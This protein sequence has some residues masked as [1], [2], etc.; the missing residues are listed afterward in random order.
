[1]KLNSRF[2]AV[3][4]ALTL[5]V[6]GA[7]LPAHAA[8]ITFEAAPFGGGFTGPITE[9][10]FTYTKASGGLFVE[11]FGHPGHDMEGT[12]IEG[13]GVLDIV[14]SSSGAFTF[15]SLDYAAYAG[16][17]VGSQTL[18]ITGYLGGLAVGADTYTLANTSSASPAFSNWTLESASSLAGVKIDDLKITL[19]GGLTDS[20]LFFQAV[21]NVVLG[22]ATVPEPATWAM[23]L[24]GFG[25]V[26]ATLRARRGM[27]SATA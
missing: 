3:A 24:V 8:T 18:H 27:A 13:G 14:Q 21:D 2:V 7:G 10:G 5:G 1:M 4:A 12:A 6:L 11:S 25:A 23:M 19:N 22:S 26:G 16:T 20:S 15:F 17:G 9:S